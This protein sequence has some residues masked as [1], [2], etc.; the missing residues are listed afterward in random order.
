[1]DALLKKISSLN[2]CQ[3]RKELLGVKNF[4]DFLILHMGEDCNVQLVK[5]HYPSSEYRYLILPKHEMRTSNISNIGTPPMHAMPHFMYY[6]SIQSP[7]PSIGTPTTNDNSWIGSKNLE[8]MLQ[9]NHSLNP[10]SRKEYNLMFKPENFQN[11]GQNEK[12]SMQAMSYLS[13]ISKADHPDDFSMGSYGFNNDFQNKFPEY[14]IE[15]LHTPRSSSKSDV[16]IEDKSGFTCAL[17]PS[18]CL[19]NENN[20]LTVRSVK[21]SDE[22]NRKPLLDEEKS[23]GEGGKIRKKK[24]RKSKSASKKQLKEAK[25]ILNLFGN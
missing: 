5:P 8:N 14:E 1:M 4:K 10:S 6:P 11:S 12:Q 2:G 9:K 24:I 7:L 19:S 22:D 21:S 3:V 13:G 23:S 18:L 25:Q 15:S 20:D 17:Y 16:S